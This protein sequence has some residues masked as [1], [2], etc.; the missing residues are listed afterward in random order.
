MN[1]E[2]RGMLFRVGAALGA[3][4]CVCAGAAEA[5]QKT[6]VTLVSS[7]VNPPSVSNV[8]YLAAMAGSFA[9]TVK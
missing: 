8:Y 3:L 9:I 4:L 7:T 2:E 5:Q 6:T 1:V